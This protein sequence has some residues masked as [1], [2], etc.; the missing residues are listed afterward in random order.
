MLH[1]LLQKHVE[2][3]NTPTHFFFSRTKWVENVNIVDMF[4]NRLVMIVG[5]SELDMRGRCSAGQKVLACIIVRLALA[6]TF[7]LNCGILSLD[8]PTTNLDQVG[9][10]KARNCQ[11]MYFN[12]NNMHLTCHLFEIIHCYER[13][14]PHYS[15]FVTAQLRNNIDSSVTL[16][17]SQFSLVQEVRVHHIKKSFLKFLSVFIRPMQ[18]VLPVLFA[19]S[20]RPVSSKRI[21]S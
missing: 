2:S 11:V 17:W 13:N 4:S 6:E 8:E 15:G 1:L 21:S 12:P 20:L 14:W 5:G 18:K 9:L 3:H 16:C 10:I 7:C 19:Q